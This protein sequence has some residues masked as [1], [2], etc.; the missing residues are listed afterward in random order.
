[1]CSCT[2]TRLATSNVLLKLWSTDPSVFNR[3]SW[4]NC[5][6]VGERFVSRPHLLGEVH[7]G[8]YSLTSGK[9]KGRK[10]ILRMM[11]NEKRKMKVMERSRKSE[12][13]LTSCTD[14]MR[15]TLGH[16]EPSDVC[17]EWVWQHKTTKTYNNY[18]HIHVFMMCFVLMFS[19]SWFSRCHWCWTSHR[20]AGWFYASTA[21]HHAYSI[22]KVLFFSSG[23]C[24]PTLSCHRPLKLYPKFLH[25]SHRENGSFEVLS[26]HRRLQ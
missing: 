22:P 14:E 10:N 23:C 2:G 4:F 17:K 9:L 24:S 1:M 25:S 18:A 11:R 20:S 3:I 6:C 15:Q 13:T 7:K 16:L 19:G 21:V 8:S 5:S 12:K 26:L